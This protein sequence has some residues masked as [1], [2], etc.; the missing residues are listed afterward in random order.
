[1]SIKNVISYSKIHQAGH[2]KEEVTADSLSHLC[3]ELWPAIS[4]INPAWAG[5]FRNIR[6]GQ[7]NDDSDTVP[8]GMEE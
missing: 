3:P 8:G 5:T 2:S 1:M 4:H 6:L 7:S